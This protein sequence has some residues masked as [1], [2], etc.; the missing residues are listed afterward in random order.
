MLAESRSNTPV[1][2]AARTLLT[3]VGPSSSPPV[4]HP[5]GLPLSGATSQRP[6]CDFPPP[7]RP[8]AGLPV[9]TNHVA[10]LT[11]TAMA[12]PLLATP[13]YLVELPHRPSSRRP[14]H[15]RRRFPTPFGDFRPHTSPRRPPRGHQ[16]PGPGGAAPG[17][18]TARQPA[19]HHAGRQH[20][21]GRDPA[22]HSRQR[23]LHA[24]S[25]EIM[26]QAVTHPSYR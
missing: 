4:A 14:P 24:T 25:R 12:E 6:L 21:R 3:L 8:S 2:A 19:A 23:L 13:S 26:K 16:L 1:A 10:N 20:G 11:Q 22:L 15:H 5:A 17:G 9:G 18:A 7:Y